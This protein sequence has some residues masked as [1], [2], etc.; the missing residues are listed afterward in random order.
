M[1]YWVGVVPAAALPELRSQTS[2]TFEGVRLSQP[3]AKAD[4]VALIALTSPPTLVTIGSV[5]GWFLYGEGPSSATG[6]VSVSY[7]AGSVSVGTGSA[8][9]DSATA[10]AGSGRPGVDLAELGLALAGRVDADEDLAGLYPV[11][12]DQFARLTSH[13][14][15]PE[16]LVSVALPIEAPTRAEAVREFWSVV[17]ELGSGEL[18]VFVSPRGDELDLQA[19]VLDE[20]VNLDPEE[21]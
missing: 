1:G 12:G 2:Y 4:A 21:D 18:P 15:A 10:P 14:P 17:G 20:P 3:P 19:Y 11:N 7:A 16:W 8:G 5:A 6:Q 13:A 9:L